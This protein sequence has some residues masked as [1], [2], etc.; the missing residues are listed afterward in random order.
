M[1]SAK[2]YFIGTFFCCC[3]WTSAFCA[4]PKPAAEILLEIADSYY[5][6]EE[7]GLNRVS[8]YVKSPEI[9]AGLDYSSRKA[10]GNTKYETVIVPGKSVEVIIQDVP[11]L[12]G[13]DMRGPML[14]F[15]K[16][17]ERWLNELMG[18]LDTF[19]N[20]IHPKKDLD[21]YDI[22]WIE[23]EEGKKM[24]LKRVSQVMGADKNERRDRGGMGGKEAMMRN[25]MEKL[26]QNVQKNFNNG[27]G[28]GPKLAI[29]AQDAG[30]VQISD[31]EVN[32]KFEGDNLEIHLD[33]SGQISMLLMEKDDQRQEVRIKT[34]KAGK[35]WLLESL[36]DAK[37]DAQDR[38]IERN[39]IRYS[40]VSKS[41]IP[42]ISKI[43]LK[44]LDAKGKLID[45][46]DDP[47]PVSVELSSHMVEV[48]K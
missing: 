10:I 23:G 18:H 44:S 33:R 42:V 34:K 41:G 24:T 15:G 30:R 6:Y 47:N 36:D 20:S 14:V 17:M 26:R 27:R 4:D 37:F 28:R 40:Y 3:A 22:Q 38:L 39:L 29:G 7:A 1:L 8:C 9:L 5:D 35:Q 25:K 21:G 48:R 32:I 11:N 45:R 43:T 46:R 12:R 13:P 31:V 2:I 19:P 16:K